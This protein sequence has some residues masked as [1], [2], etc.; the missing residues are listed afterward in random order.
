VGLVGYTSGAAAESV[1]SLIEESQT[2]MLG[3]ASGNM[4]I[5]NEKLHMQYHVRAGYDLEYKRMVK[6]VKDFGM[7]RVGYV[8]LK[9]TSAANAA[10]MTAALETVGVKLTETIA[11]DR[12]TASFEAE[13]K[14]LLAAKLDCVLFTANASPVVGIVDQMAAGGYTGMYFSS[15][16]AGQ[17]LI[18]AMAQKQQSVVMA[19][20]VPRPNALGL[21]VVN[22]CHKDMAALGGGARVGFTSLE[23]YITGSVAVEA[24]KAGLKG[25]GLSRARFRESLAE[26]RTD[27]GGYAIDFSG[28]VTQ[29]SRFV[30]VVAIDR[31]GRVIG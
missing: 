2:V 5:R 23:G 14:K 16:F 19:Q 12:N 27:L 11:L 20:V 15:S 22:R 25:G 29:G 18:E 28:G 21:Q 4:G 6:Y 17:A 1:A 26:L 10:A 9:D 31:R 3:A 24:A 13:S 30:D 8:Y 7:R